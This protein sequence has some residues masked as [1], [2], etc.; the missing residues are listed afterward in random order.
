MKAM[1]E[2]VDKQ[3][4][5][6]TAVPHPLRD[7]AL[8]NMVAVKNAI[9]NMLLYLA[10]TGHKPWRPHPLGMDEKIKRLKALTVSLEAML[11]T[12]K[13]NV[14][15][16]DKIHDDILT[17]TLVSTFGAIEESI[18]FYNT[19]EDITRL[20]AQKVDEFTDS[21]MKESKQHRVE[22]LTDELFFFLERMIL[23]GIDWG[24]II[25]EYHRKWTVNMKRYADAKANN[26]EWDKRHEGKL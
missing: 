13:E 11:D 12:F 19:Q 21:M 8:K 15:P 23:A 17:R 20:Y 16:S 4:E 6:M 18:E 24:A 9:E 26:F 22:E 14:A 1:N 10:A 2:L 3:R 7:D 25:N 5:L